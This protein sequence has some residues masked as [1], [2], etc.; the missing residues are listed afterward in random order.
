MIR[1]RWRAEQE[2]TSEAGASWAL[3]HSDGKLSAAQELRLS[4]WIAEDAENARAFNDAL[5]ALDALDANAAEPE[6]LAFR[7]AALLDRG[8]RKSR[9]GWGS[10]AAMLA[11]LMVFLMVQLA[12][13][14]EPSQSPPAAPV[15]PYAQASAPGVYQT[16]LGE[17]S[18]IRLPDGSTATLDTNTRVRVAYSESER[19]VYLLRGQALFDVAHRK[20]APFRVYAGS[21]RIE[22]V[23]TVFNV[24]LDGNVV[25]VAMVEGKVRIRSQAAKL[26]GVPR[27]PVEQILTAGE[28]LSTLP[29]APVVVAA[30]NIQQVTSWKSGVLTFE[31]TPLSEAVAE[32]NRYTAQPIAIADGEVGRHR[33]SGLFLSS[34][35][36]RFAQAAAEIFPVEVVRSRDGGP[37]LRS[38]TH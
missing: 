9:K 20:P 18:Q 21:E 26:G 6:I 1:R 27:P 5:W 32:I 34:D 3:L 25:R 8:V 37:V 31:D 23:G 12:P 28:A 36:E 13:K 10:A 15:R 29:E 22:A 2:A 35:P 24:R 11:V 33:I 17:S 14:R 19:A 4:E 16:G 38:R 7:N 30:V